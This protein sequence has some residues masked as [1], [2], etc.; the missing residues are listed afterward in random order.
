MS[1]FAFDTRDLDSM[2]LSLPGTDVAPSPSQAYEAARDEMLRFGNIDYQERNRYEVVQG[3]LDAF[4]EVS[5]RALFNPEEIQKDQTAQRGA[6][7]ARLRA[8][9]SAAGGAFPSDDEI[10]AQADQR[11]R[12]ARERYLTL[13]A[14]REAGGGSSAAWWAGMGGAVVGSLADPLNLLTL[15]FGPAARAGIMGAAA[16]TGAIG[17]ATQVANEVMNF[18]ARQRIDENY[19]AADAAG[20]V[21]GA[22]IGGAV[23]G[24]GIKAIGKGI[25]ATVDALR[26]R[27]GREALDAANVLERDAVSRESSPIQGDADVE[28]RHIAALEKAAQDIDAGRPVDVQDIAPRIDPPA[29]TAE[30][31]RAETASRMARAEYDGVLENARAIEAEIAN[32]TD[33]AARAGSEAGDLRFAANKP[34]VDVEALARAE[35]LDVDTIGVIRALETDIAAGGP[36]RRI[37]D[38]DRQLDQARQSV[39]G[40]IEAARQ[41]L[42]DI[43]ASKE[44]ERDALEKRLTTARRQLEHA[45]GEQERLARAVAK[46]ERRL[47]RVKGQPPRGQDDIPP[48]PDMVVS[49]EAATR[50]GADD[51]QP[52]APR[53][54]PDILTGGEPSPPPSPRDIAATPPRT[55][56]ELAGSPELRQALE[57]EVDRVMAARMI[58]GKELKLAEFD[59]EGRLVERDAEDALA[60]IDREIRMAAELATCAFG[61]AAT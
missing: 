19:T 55:A 23:I 16:V 53:S 41:A 42:R 34:I 4:A 5:G 52:A 50:L 3:A 12:A 35:A 18:E 40:D 2:L 56:E 24:G 46:S 1:S 15:P 26:A 29:L 6:A 39:Q 21:A 51:M 10:D 61:Q 58:E 49:D 27:G 43:A 54:A 31:A 45:T 36:K 17:G 14:Q 13:E 9:I 37:A 57:A 7:Y 25:G 22:A 32:L 47:D 11:G 8:E 60:D 48:S 30:R 33:A 44:A 20:N 38:L 59:A 28:A